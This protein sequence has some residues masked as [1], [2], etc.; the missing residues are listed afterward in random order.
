MPYRLILLTFLLLTG[1]RELSFGQ[2]LV[3]GI[4][5]DSTMHPVASATV[6]YSLPSNKTI[7]GFSI[8][9]AN[10]EF[11][12]SIRTQADSIKLH[13]DHISFEQKSLVVKNISASYNFILSVKHTQL[14]EAVS[15]AYAGAIYRKRDTINYNVDSFTSK[16]DRTIADVIK[17]L[18]GV[19]LRGDEIWYQGA[20]IQNFYVNGLDLM[21]GR[22]GIVTNNLPS[23]AV[24]DIQIIEN[25]QPIKL[26]ATASPSDKASLNL[27]LKSKVKTTGSGKIGI[28]VAPLLWDLG[29]TPMT[30]TN[31]FQMINSFQ[32][33]N[34]GYSVGRQLK[35][36][37]PDNDSGARI[38]ALLGIESAGSPP[39]DESKWLDN[40][41]KL[42]S[43]NMLFKGN[44]DMQWTANLAYIN[45]HQQTKSFST[46][47]IATTGRTVY[48]SDDIHNSYNINELQ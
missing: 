31:K 9:N 35:S 19:E 15:N 39:F 30:F 16:Q 25:D 22:Y 14:K 3:K 7:L 28:G 4:L 13:I 26:L 42:L 8:S 20:K 41:A 17:K 33:N 44:N 32:A 6:T 36:L 18:P 11:L 24:K 47:A 10:G 34:T 27:V 48:T 1:N 21:G 38:T 23:D 46:T 12:L 40:N 2:T 45:D 43:T 5:T 37:I 29:L